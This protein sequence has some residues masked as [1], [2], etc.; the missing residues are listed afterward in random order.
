MLI[1]KYSNPHRR[2]PLFHYHLNRIESVELP[3]IGALHGPVIGFGLEL[4]PTFDLHVASEKYQ[5]SIPETRLGLVADLVGITRLSRVIGPA[6]NSPC[7]H[8]CRL[9]LRARPVLAAPHKLLEDPT[10]LCA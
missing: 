1:E 10:R 2:E 4:A 7:C 9:M 5:L 6:S 3:V 8:F